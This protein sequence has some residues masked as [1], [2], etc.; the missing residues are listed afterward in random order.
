MG[1]MSRC[2]KAV[3]LTIMMSNIDR[4][5]SYAMSILDVDYNASTKHAI[6]VPLTII[7]LFI[8]PPRPCSY[9]LVLHVTCCFPHILKKSC[10]FHISETLQKFNL[11][12]QILC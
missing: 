6:F 8:I 2:Q 4:L 5:F 11:F 3:I 12:F 7:Y 9:K 10:E 1:E